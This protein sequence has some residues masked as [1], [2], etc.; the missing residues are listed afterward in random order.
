MEG[1]GS[2]RL[3]GDLLGGAG[4]RAA[5]F[6]WALEIK[7]CPETLPVQQLAIVRHEITFLFAWLRLTLKSTSILMSRGGGREGGA[8]RRANKVPGTI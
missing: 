4:A 3:N 6:S 2:R 1:G 8:G 7:P 5:P